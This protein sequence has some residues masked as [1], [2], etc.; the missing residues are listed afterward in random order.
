ME[1]DFRDL[2]LLAMNPSS[3][4]CP[5]TEEDGSVKDLM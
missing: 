3:L 2:N 4:F 1:I 5:Q